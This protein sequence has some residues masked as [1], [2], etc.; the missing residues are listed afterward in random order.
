MAIENLRT[1]SILNGGVGSGKSRAALAYYYQ[2]AGK[3]KL[4]INGKGKRTFMKKAVDLYIITT[5][6]KRD[7]LEWEDELAPFSLTTKKELNMLNINIQVDSW[8][9]VG[10]YVDIEDAF[11]IFDEQ[12][13]VGAGA[14]TKSFIKISKSNDWILLS[15]T[16]GDTWM[17]YIPVMI[18]NGYYKN[19]T[20][21]IRRHVVYNQFV[22]F[23]MVDRYLE[24]DVLEKLRDEILVNM[25]HKRHTTTNN[26]HIKT[27]YDIKNYQ[28]LMK[29]RWNIFKDQPIQNV[30]E[31]CYALRRVINSDKTRIDALK[32]L[33]EKHPKLIIFY[34]FNYELIILRKIGYDL[35]IPTTEWNGH[36][37]ELIPKTDNWLYLAQYTSNAEG[38]N[39]IETN[40][41]VFY[42]QNYSYKINQQAA[43]RINRRNTPFEELY[44]YRFISDASM[45]LAIQKTLT[46]KKNFNE[47]IFLQK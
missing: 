47:N 35:G 31:L 15:A 45:D 29:D 44:Y 14:W 26:I 9:N 18:A 33:T 3:G 21:F 32:K 27:K 4:K 34:N 23:P 6:R 2:K 38:W 1:G 17:D 8:N 37:H 43:G 41:M 7:T 28:T 16:P 5:A 13:V 30:S 25:K 42:S 46:E 11:F 24:T 20:Q 39:C 12:R 10:K 22:K 36:K 19:R 40:A